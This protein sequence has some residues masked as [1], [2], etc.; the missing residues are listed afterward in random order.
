MSFVDTVSLYLGVSTIE[1]STVVAVLL[2]SPVDS[3]QWRFRVFQKNGT[4][5]ESTTRRYMPATM[6]ST[7]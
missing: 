6:S 2:F 1:G 3:V 4:Q 5:N 7:V